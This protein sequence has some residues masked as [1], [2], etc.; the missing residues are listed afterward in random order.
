MTNSG[1]TVTTWCGVP[2]AANASSS[3]SVSPRSTLSTRTP[4]MRTEGGRV[5]EA[6]P[7]RDFLRQG[8]QLPCGCDDLR[9]FN[10]VQA[11][12]GGTALRCSQRMPPVE[13]GRAGQIDA[14]D[15]G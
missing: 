3:A 6:L 4:R 8:D 13:A 5:S 7:M 1:L 11:G 15:A 12:A 10:T 14:Q 9:C 2:D